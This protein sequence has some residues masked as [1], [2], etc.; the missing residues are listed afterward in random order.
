MNWEMGQK[1]LSAVGSLFS[2]R[3]LGLNLVLLFA[4]A[5][6]VACATGA[7]PIQLIYP[8][9]GVDYSSIRNLGEKTRQVFPYFVKVIVYADDDPATIVGAGSGI[10]IDK[11]GHIVTAAHIVKDEQ[12]SAVVTTAAG[13]TLPARIIH[14]DAGNELALLQIAIKYQ[15]PVEL[16]HVDMLSP[17]D[18]VFAIGTP[19][20]SSAIV[21]VGSVRS[22]RLSKSFR[23]GKY[24]FRDP[25]VLA[26][27]IDTGYSGGPVFN[28]SGK[29][30]GMVVGFDPGRVDNDEMEQ[31]GDVYAIPASRLYEFYRK[32]QPHSDS[33][34]DV[35]RQGP[36]IVK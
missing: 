4:A 3:L 32:S 11:A 23:Y 21:T 35:I 31:V 8:H 19:P 15:A 20:A 13:S 28:E 6:M 17:G 18:K 22:A 5:I 14:V 34:L 16:S 25:V 1:E 30:V 9:Q 27:Y 36:D 10:L 26:M 12:Y 33:I 7:K 29:L 24:G 2:D